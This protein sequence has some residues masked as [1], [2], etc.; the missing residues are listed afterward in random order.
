MKL[1]S[2]LATAALSVALVGAP[3]PASMAQSPAAAPAAAAPA[4]RLASI[5]NFRDVAGG[6]LS[7][8]GGA[9]MTTGVVYR[10]G[11]LKGLSDPDAATLVHLGITDIYD[12]RS[13]TAA[14][15]SPDPV[16]SG[17]SYHRIDVFA[18]HSKPYKGRTTA[19]ARAYMR[20]MNR[21]FVTDSRQR[22]RIAQALRAISRAGGP[23]LIHCAAG[24]DR[25]GWLSA[26]LQSI[27][28]ANRA[29]IKG[30]YLL[31]NTYRKDLI[32][33]KVAAA[34]KTSATRAAIVSELELLRPSYLQAGLDKAVAKYGSLH[35]YWTKGLK[36]SGTTIGTLRA[37]LR[38]A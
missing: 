36:L 14:K 2:I 22:S 24:K 26:M 3:V 29:T 8:S 27:A 32:D 1:V 35:R 10:S 12:L 6:G 18:G 34:R 37:K 23:V 33:A 5:G 28:G 30:E 21:A 16:P 4:P 9:T 17:V 7:L 13:A 11:Q 38:Q 15:A 25:T 31:S 19:G 20:A